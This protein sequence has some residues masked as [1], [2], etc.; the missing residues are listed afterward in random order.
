[1]W[2]TVDSTGNPPANGPLVSKLQACDG[3]LPAY[4]V[5]VGA[6]QPFE[7]FATDLASNGSTTDLSGS[8]LVIDQ[9]SRPLLNLVLTPLAANFTAGGVV[10]A[11]TFTSGIAPGGI[12]SIFGTGLASSPGSTAVDVDGEALVVLSASPFQVNAVLPADVSPGT[13]TLRVKSTFGTAQQ[14]VTVSAVAPAIFLVGNPPVGAVE[15]QDGSLNGPANPG[16]R[17]QVLVAYAT[18]L[19]AT[20]RNG[21]L[22]IANSTVTAVVNGVEVPTSFAGLAPGYQGLYQVNIPIP[23]GISPE[24][25]IPLN[26]KQGGI[27]S[28]SVVIAIQ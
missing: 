4:Q 27:S 16:A 7:A 11:A 8:A 1:M 22:S 6:A 24:L 2:D 13:H 10:N 14:S 20:S 28:N 21:A 18:G 9:A 15:N 3:L 17:G 23:S 12:V 5:T 25:G 26:L 19:G